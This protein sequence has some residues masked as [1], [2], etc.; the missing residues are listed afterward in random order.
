[1][2]YCS[3]SLFFSHSQFTNKKNITLQKVCLNRCLLQCIYNECHQE[4]YV[5]TTVCLKIIPKQLNGFPSKFVGGCSMGQ[6]RTYTI[7]VQI[8]GQI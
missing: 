2:C 7:L 3:V 1:M 8:T 5:F 4:G 6:E